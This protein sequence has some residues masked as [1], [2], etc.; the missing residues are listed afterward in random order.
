MRAA[1]PLV[2]ANQ[3]APGERERDESVAF[4]GLL[5]RLFGQARFECECRVERVKLEMIM[6][7]AMRFRWGRAAVTDRL[8]GRL[9]ITGPGIAALMP[10]LRPRR[11]NLSRREN[12]TFPGEAGNVFLNRLPFPLCD[13][14]TRSFS[15]QGHF[16]TARL[17]GHRR[18]PN[19]GTGQ[20]LPLQGSLSHCPN[21]VPMRGRRSDQKESDGKRSAVSDFSAA[22]RGLRLS[23]PAPSRVA[24]VGIDFL[25]EGRSASVTP[26]ISEGASKAS[27]EA[28]T[29]LTDLD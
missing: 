28:G 2:R 6:R 3:L 10:E 16:K 26:P 9:G 5:D 27:G 11:E 20:L 15:R 12:E 7:H 19:V 8:S 17:P 13:F 14:Q 1:T 18:L 4:D 29:L 24:V 23:E 21:V 25:I 22:H